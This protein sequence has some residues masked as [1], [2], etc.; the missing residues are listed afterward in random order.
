MVRI[1]DKVV[2]KWGWTYRLE[3]REEAFDRGPDL[4][5]LRAANMNAA[6]K[7]NVTMVELLK[8]HGVKERIA[9]QHY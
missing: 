3:T 1:V 6:W 8:A 9:S 5:F 2:D 7:G 4:R